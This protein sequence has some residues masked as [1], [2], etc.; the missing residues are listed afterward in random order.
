MLQRDMAEATKIGKE[1]AHGSPTLQ[2]AVAVKSAAAGRAATAEAARHSGKRNSD[3]QPGY[4]SL[5]FAKV[6]RVAQGH[7]KETDATV[8]HA[9]APVEGAPASDKADIAHV[10]ATYNFSFDHFGRAF[11]AVDALGLKWTTHQQ[12]VILC[13]ATM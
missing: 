8:S 4:N 7:G 10:A 9:E 6:A 2:H 1:A 12:R 11:K 13:R 3:G 5:E